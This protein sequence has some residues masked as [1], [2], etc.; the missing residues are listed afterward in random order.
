M[1]ESS[2]DSEKSNVTSRM[3]SPKTYT[4]LMRL[5]ANLAQVRAVIKEAFGKNINLTSVHHD[6]EYVPQGPMYRNANAFHR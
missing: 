1:N 6:P 5:E 3:E 4:K 2:Q